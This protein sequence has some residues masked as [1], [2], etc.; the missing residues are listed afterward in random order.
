MLVAAK[1]KLVNLVFKEFSFVR[2]TKTPAY[3][4]YIMIVAV[5]IILVGCNLR[6][7]AVSNLSAVAVSSTAVE[8][9]WTVPELPTSR[10]TELQVTW[11]PEV[12]MDQPLIVPPNA[13]IERIEGLLPN[14]QYTFSVV[15]IDHNGAKSSPVM[16]TVAT[17]LAPVENLTANVVDGGQLKLTWVDPP[18]SGLARVE[19]TWAPQ[20]GAS[21]PVS[22]E[23]GL[24]QATITGL[25]PS[26]MYEFRAIAVYDDGMLSNPSV[27]NTTSPPVRFAWGTAIASGPHHPQSVYAAD[28]DG[29]GYVDI[30]AAYSYS[31]FARDQRPEQIVWYRNTTGSGE[32]APAR[33]VTE[34]LL[35]VRSVYATDLDGDGDTD[36]L[37]ASEWRDGITWYENTD[38]NGT[39]STG[40]VIGVEEDRVRSVSAADLDG[41]GDDD[42]LVAAWGLD[43]VA[44]YENVD[45]NGTFLLG[46]RI[47]S[48]T[49]GIDA[50]SA[51]DIDGDGDLDV[52]ASSSTTRRIVWFANVDSSGTF[53]NPTDVAQY[54]DRSSSRVVSVADLDGDGD[55]D[56]L[57]RSA[58]ARAVA[59]YEN[60]D[61][62]GAFSD[63]N[64]L[65]GSSRRA[66]PIQAADLDNDGDLDVLAIDSFSNRI[67]WHENTD[68]GGSFSPQIEISTKSGGAVTL[69]ATDVD[70]DQ[71]TDVV[72]AVEVDGTI[73]WYENIN[74]TGSF[75]SGTG[76]GGGAN[77][78]TS[79][80]AV[81]LDRDGD[82]DVLSAAPEENRVMWYQNTDG[83]GTFSQAIDITVDS[84]RAS[85]FD[86]S[87][88][89]G[90]E[91]ID[92]VLD[93]LGRITWYANTNG[94]GSFSE[95]IVVNPRGPFPLHNDV[96]LIDL[97]GDRDNDVVGLWY[98]GRFSGI[99]VYEN[100][101]GKGSFAAGF[102][103]AIELVDARFIVPMDWDEDGDIDLFAG[104]MFLENQTSRND[105]RVPFHFVA[106]PLSDHGVP[107]QASDFNGDGVLDLLVGSGRGER[108]YLVLLLTNAES[109]Q[110][111]RYGRDIASSIYS[112]DSARSVDLDGDGDMDILS[113][114]R[115][116]PPVHWYE[117]IDGAGSFSD[118]R[119]IAGS[120][121]APVA[122][123]T[124]DLDG[125][126]DMDV[127]SAGG[128]EIIWSE[129]LLVD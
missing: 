101:D 21:Q 125:D 82:V 11:Q 65:P 127:L 78:V 119:E 29:D 19:I 118:Q 9:V 43:R 60:T 64:E 51:A 87:D 115:N 39:F 20:D 88:I 7:L 14:T 32:F 41:D 44:W 69:F 47:T 84:S 123:A 24:Q 71:D 116:N 54:S 42:V 4:F 53:S 77:G 110:P 2:L 37:S 121:F 52:V 63:A 59:W 18:E 12:G 61:G 25:L 129:N 36:L 27:L 56:I 17:P 49:E 117:N 62:T 108:A 93:R 106:H 58:N 92:V 96:R 76:L 95:G 100:S 74:G 113:A 89:D 112:F 126:G 26:S 80:S 68:G 35:G 75:R 48:H 16:A 30:V 70:G 67:F 122:V 102:D 107:L 90:D 13:K 97:D 111:S 105:D 23:P 72:T 83:Q 85:V 57:G 86:A 5:G 120:S 1:A 94:L 22:I 6:P 33:V 91:D 98:N 81:D 10:H 73:A 15:A 109:R 124:A 40:T 45:G 114:V 99:T 31:Q 50:I 55:L 38:G 66:T 104:S 79:I 46:G 28:L 3:F 128:D 34:D 8:L 103:I